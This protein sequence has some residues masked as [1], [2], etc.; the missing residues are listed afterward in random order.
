MDSS[1]EPNKYHL[2]KRKHIKSHRFL[3]TDADKG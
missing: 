1:P 2:G 3:I